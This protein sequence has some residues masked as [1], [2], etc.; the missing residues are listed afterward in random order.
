MVVLAIQIKNAGANEM[1]P[2][3]RERER[4]RET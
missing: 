3:R 4:E 2:E 1:L